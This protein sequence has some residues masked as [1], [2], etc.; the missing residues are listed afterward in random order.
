MAFLQL[1]LPLLLLLPV[2]LC[3]W[4][5]T[6]CAIHHSNS[7][8]GVDDILGFGCVRYS[9]NAVGA[10]FQTVAA[11]TAVPGLSFALG[12]DHLGV[13][14]GYHENQRLAVEPLTASSNGVRRTFAI[15]LWKSR[16]GR[17]WAFGWQRLRTPPSSRHRQAF[18][19]GRAL[20]GF[21]AQ[22]GGGDSSFHAG[23]HAVETTFIQ[24]TDTYLTF[25]GT[26]THWPYYDLMTMAI[27]APEPRIQT[28]TQR[29]NDP[30]SQPVPKAL[31]HPTKSP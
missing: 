22:L 6:G 20:A 1:P 10:R 17:V 14:L 2:V 8:A 18:I 15:P 11:E 26:N 7:L 5:F 13:S 25:A 31:T 19:T 29:E 16:S 21:A 12:L 9:T 3:P 4:L 30:P 24:S 23:T 28:Q 27:D